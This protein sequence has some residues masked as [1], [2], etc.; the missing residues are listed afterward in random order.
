MKPH[1]NANGEICNCGFG[2]Y[3]EPVEE[4]LI[5]EAGA[6]LEWL[7]E[8]NDKFLQS[9]EGQLAFDWLEK[10]VEANEKVD[11]L[12][13]WLWREIK[14]GRINPKV[15]FWPDADLAH[16][17]D[18]YAS[19][20][21]TRR[22]VDIMQ[23]TLPEVVAKI[24]EWDEELAAK[25]EGSKVEGGRVV[26]ELDD[27]WTI[28]QVTTEE[29]AQQEGDAMG[30]CV[31]GY[32]HQIVSGE[33]LIYS[34][35]D[36]KNQPH[37]TIEIQPE[38]E[39]N[40]EVIDQV[41]KFQKVYNLVNTHFP[42]LRALIKGGGTND[43]VKETIENII[44]DSSD[45][46]YKEFVT[47]LRARLEDKE[48]E[49]YNEKI[50]DI[51]VEMN[52]SDGAVIQIQG[53]ENKMP[54]DKYQGL[55]GNWL[56]SFDTPPYYE[57]SV[58]HLYLEAPTTLDALGIWT[59]PSRDEY[60]YVYDG[61]EYEQEFIRPRTVDDYFPEG[62]EH[63][64]LHD[65][66]G[67]GELDD[68]IHRQHISDAHWEAILIDT[69]NKGDKDSVMKLLQY[70]SEAEKV[71]PNEQYPSQF[72]DVVADFARDEIYPEFKTRY[73]ND[74]SS[75]PEA[76]QWAATPEGQYVNI[77]LGY[78]YID[79]NEEIGPPEVPEE[80]NVLFGP[81]V[82]DEWQEQR[83]QF[84][85][86]L[87]ESN[88]NDPVPLYPSVEEGPLI[89]QNVPWQDPTNID[90]LKGRFGS[91]FRRWLKSRKSNIL[92]EIHAGLD[93]SVWDNAHSP[94]PT[95]KP[96]IGQWIKQKITDA[97]ARHG[98]THMEE[99]MSLVITGSLTTYQYSPES[100][101]DISVFVN[102]DRFPD[103]SRAEMIGIM[104]QECDGVF[105]PGTSHPLQCYIVPEGFKYQDLYKPG[106]R[107]AY[108]L[109]D[110]R[111]IVPPEKDRAHDV[112][113]EMNEAYTI[114][115]ENA[116]KME[117][118]IRYEPLKAVQYY[119]QVQARRRRDQQHGKGD[120]APSNISY[121]MMESRGL[122]DQIKSLKKQHRIK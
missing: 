79:P 36:P 107:S 49:Y 72:A 113:R 40:K 77:L 64:Y 87:E 76:R 70:V 59:D 29:G 51:L 35:R 4:N 5:K 23:L 55:I 3:N 8:R 95:L 108:S 9:E 12:A 34:L 47:I 31:G 117:K 98:Y 89:E 82:T 65:V 120:F 15:N 14:K 62:Q 27:G 30:H 104:M 85:K 46:D 99:W 24:K 109:E 18:W 121:K 83:D 71:E 58:Y 41:N 112:T 103:W 32:G 13:P 73:F 37:A 28:Q 111:W 88:R 43:Q 74:Q 61:G 119:G 86:T 53:K 38:Y 101:C 116:D 56:L 67:G 106:L 80:Q 97:L 50:S 110:D 17:A 81:G 21:P 33:T 54:I 22:G 78:N 92:D 39:S 96:E 115:L 2:R 102:A 91:R 16:A 20:S 6:K 57:K 69:F 7:R 94:R 84:Q 1:Y 48:K 122:F 42:V 105:V 60:G 26:A 11:P 44:E 90:N 118:L 66:E 75:V 52:P 45:I 68:E 19:N 25:M 93:P 114:A 100:D 63:G 10:K